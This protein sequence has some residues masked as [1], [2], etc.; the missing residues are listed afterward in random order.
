MIKNKG[1]QLLT[2]SNYKSGQT[3]FFFSA[4]ETI[5]DYHIRLC[6]TQT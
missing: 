6:N 1:H 3:R 4:S 2:S 5:D